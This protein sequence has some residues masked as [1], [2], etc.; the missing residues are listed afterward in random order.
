[1]TSSSPRQR[2]L[3]AL[4]TSPH[5]E[6]ALH[7]AC[8]LAVRLHAELCGLFIEDVNLL[9]LASLPFVTEIDITSARERQVEISQMERS[10]R[11]AADQSQK[12]LADLAQQYRIPWSFLVSRGSVVPTLLDELRDVD[13]LL[14]GREGRVVRSLTG[15]TPAA[16]PVGTQPVLVVVEGSRSP[17]PAMQLASEIAHDIGASVQVLIVEAEDRPVD[18]L[19]QQCDECLSHLGLTAFYRRP[20]FRDA[21]QF[22]ETMCIEPA[23]MLIVNRDFR[24]IDEKTIDALMSSLDCPVALVK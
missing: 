1:M 9:H 3:L 5:A 23:S 17:L 7:L 2:I 20:R 19:K 22:V 15:S 4:D 14:I 6:T 16:R 13:L 24:W 18:L 10:L 11:V 8:R 21:A 12:Q